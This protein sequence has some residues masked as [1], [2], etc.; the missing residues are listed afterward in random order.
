MLLPALT[1]AKAKAQGIQCMSNHRQLALAW[2]MY[3]EES[4]GYIVYAS[5]LPGG[6]AGISAAEAAARDPYAWTLSHLDFD[7]NNRANWDPQVDLMLRPLWPYSGK[8]LGIYKCPSDRST[9]APG[10]V[11][12]PRVRSMSMN[13]YIGGFDGTDGGWG[14]AAPFKVFSKFNDLVTAPGGPANY[15]LFLDMRSDHIN[16]GNYMTDYTGYGP[17]PNPQAYQYSEDMPGIYH[18][19]AC[20]FSFCDGHAEIHK[21]RDAATMMPMKP[22]GIQDIGT[23]SDWPSG[24]DVGWMQQHSTCKKF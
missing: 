12:K 8:S 17:P 14:F 15:W 2:R 5:D 11:S 10:G 4:N 3:S 24:I 19:F 22:D 18:N 7:P 16:W 1:K 20:G 6:G 9:V 23:Y 21:W 13:L